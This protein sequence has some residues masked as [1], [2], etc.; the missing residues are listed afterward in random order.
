[1]YYIVQAGDTLS[2]LAKK[3]YG[4]ARR[5]P[6]IANANFMRA[7]D[8]LHI[9]AKLLIPDPHSAGST[10]ISPNPVSDLNEKKFSL[11]H[12][13]TASRGRAMIELCAQSGVNLLV[14]QGLRTWEEQD[15]LYAKGRS[16]PPIG[17]KFIVTNAKG[18]Q[19]YHNFGW[20]LTSLCSMRLARPIG[21]TH[22]PGGK[23]PHKSENLSASNAAAI[24]G[25]SKIYLIFSTRVE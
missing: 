14:T 6:L 23:L 16:V 13:A 15:Q 4:D 8:T 11:L 24:G 1:M 12:P 5:F 7:T 21:M 25:H 2:K 17:K 20:R 9:G 3:F 10:A 18:G 19:S 22:T